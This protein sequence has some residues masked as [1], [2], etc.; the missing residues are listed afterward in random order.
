MFVKGE[1]GMEY[2]FKDFLKSAIKTAKIPF[3]VLA[4]CTFICLA[5]AASGAPIGTITLNAFCFSV[6][7]GCA[8]FICIFISMI[9]KYYKAIHKSGIA[10][11][12]KPLEPILGAILSN[13]LL[14][15]IIALFLFSSVLSTAVLADKYLDGL[16]AKE[17][18]SES[19]GTAEELINIQNVLKSKGYNDIGY[20]LSFAF[21]S[22]IKYIST[23]S[24]VICAVSYAKFFRNRPLLGSFM[25]ILLFRAAN[26]IF[27]DLLFSI[28]S[29]AVSGMSAVVEEINM[30]YDTLSNSGSPVSLLDNM[31]KN[32]AQIPAASAFQKLYIFTSLCYMIC[33][34]T[35]ILISKA[36]VAKDLT[37][38]IQ[39]D[40]KNNI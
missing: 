8:C 3:I 14:C 37:P 7:S 10:A 15:A 9:I 28:A 20:F 39:S 16:E 11:Y 33:I 30:F 18:V 25:G 36:I 4:V 13:L 19:G 1:N 23:L 31:L 40:N 5:F 22:I 6:L 29:A 26:M 21:Y 27:S 2:S 12:D 24:I 34:V 38:K 32:Y 35:L 17:S